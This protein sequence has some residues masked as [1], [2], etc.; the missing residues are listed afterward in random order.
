MVRDEDLGKLIQC[1]SCQQK[2]QTTAPNSSK[3]SAGVSRQVPK[4]PPG[5]ATKASSGSI[6]K[7]PPPSKIAEKSRSSREDDSDT[8]E[9]EDGEEDKGPVKLTKKKRIWMGWAA[10]H[11]GLSLAT[12]GMIVYLVGVVLGGLAWASYAVTKEQVIF[13][14]ALVISILSGL[15]FLVLDIW[16]RTLLIQVPKEKVS[17]GGVLFGISLGAFVLSYLTGAMI[18][19]VPL[20]AI[21]TV[22]LLCLG[23]WLAMFG[24]WLTAKGLNNNGLGTLVVTQVSCTIGLNLAG[25]ILVAVLMLGMGVKVDDLVNLDG[26]NSKAMVLAIGLGVVIA[27]NLGFYFWAINLCS[28]LVAVLGEKIGK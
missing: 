1:P 14:L 12:T 3:S 13:I 16:G 2:L 15:A 7:M 8:E 27:G 20:A 6:A 28:Q 9:D 11:K 22:I 23:Y 17:A 10:T 25:A 19:V 18:A 5:T 21:G 26:Q 4:L 24:Y